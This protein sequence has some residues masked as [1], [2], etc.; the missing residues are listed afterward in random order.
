MLCSISHLFKSGTPFSSLRVI[1]WDYCSTEHTLKEA[2][3]EDKDWATATQGFFGIKAV[4]ISRNHVGERQGGREGH[5]E[6]TK[7]RGNSAEMG[8]AQDDWIKGTM[9][10]E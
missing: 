9:G 3:P 8:P 5:Q 7:R 1:S 6:V 10:A 2:G 4:V